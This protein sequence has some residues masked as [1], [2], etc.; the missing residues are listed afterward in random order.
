V[1]VDHS[2]PHVLIN[3]YFDFYIG[4]PFDTHSADTAPRLQRIL[5]SGWRKPYHART[6]FRA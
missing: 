1:F 3:V 5:H 2:G 4:K 6:D